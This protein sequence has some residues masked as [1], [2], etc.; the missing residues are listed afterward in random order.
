MLRNPDLIE[1]FERRYAAEHPRDYRENLAIYEA[2]YEHARQLGTLPGSDPLDGI[3]VDIR[4]ARLLN[5]RRA[6]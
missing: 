6:A 1:E 3:E 4:L 5:V 2:L